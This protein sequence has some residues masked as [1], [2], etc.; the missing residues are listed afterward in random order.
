MKKDPLTKSVV[1]NVLYNGIAKLIQKF[2]GLI[3]TVIIARFLL[4]EM[5]GIYSL[6]LAIIITI[7]TFT[8]LG[9]TNTSIKFISDILTKKDKISKQK[10][11]SRFIYF[12]NI[13]IIITLVAA[14]AL[15]LLS[16]IISIK[17]FNNPQLIL[18]LKIG[19]IYLI[20][21][22][23][24]GSLRAIFISVKKINYNAISEII[25]QTSKI[26]LIITALMFYKSIAI[27]FTIF[28][29]STIL[30]AL[31]LWIVAMKKYSFILRNKKIKINKTEKKKFYSSLKWL[32]VAA[33]STIFFVNIDTFMLGIFSPAEFIGYYKSAFVIIGAVGLLLGAGAA[34]F[35]PIFMQIKKKRLQR[36][37]K[38][39]FHYMM[40]ISIPATL[41]LATIIVPLI[42][43][44]FG[45]SYVPTEYS[46]FITIT[47]VI[48]S[49]LAIEMALTSLYTPLLTAKEHQKSLAKWVII[50]IIINI[51]LNYVFIKIA[52]QF[53]IAYTIIAVA[54]ATLI[55]RYVNLLA[56][57]RIAKNKLKTFPNLKSI[58]KPLIASILMV[59]AILIYQ[60]F[61]AINILTLIIMV[62]IA[63]IVYFIIM[64]I[65]KGI[66][67]D[68][69]IMIK[70]LKP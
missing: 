37:F 10:A 20:S 50:S 67:K 40:L 3:F 57:A 64:L 25:L 68:D 6:A 17:I 24:W 62:I 47:A 21:I 49:F 39:I 19:A 9:I 56:L 34:V 33:V 30:S 4:P 8:D 55:T 46:L 26:I 45:A 41:G 63:A 1:H 36:G 2:G 59:I 27:V 69:L 61:I 44:I 13:R 70:F 43:I 66:T 11:H 38:N 32:S 22:A 54:I 12:F 31:F 28:T 53:A 15:F 23:L 14:I 29:I 60:K 18:P 65:I 35:L 51:M 42:K 5:F 52:L 48:I 7:A 16:N 58:T